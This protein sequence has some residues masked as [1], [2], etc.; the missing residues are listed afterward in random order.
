MGAQRGLKARK[1]QGV[2]P[3]GLKV[4]QLLTVAKA[5]WSCK[6]TSMLLRLVGRT[7]GYKS[8]EACK[9]QALDTHE[10]AG[11]HAFS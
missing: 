4:S 7:V 11:M 9:D 5:A 8:G 3:S 1:L 10:H 2:R 6:V